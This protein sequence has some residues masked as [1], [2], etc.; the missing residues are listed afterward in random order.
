M[1]FVASFLAFL[2]TVLFMFAL[3]P[4]AKAVGLVDAAKGRKRKGEHDNGPA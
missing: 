3:R 4:I 1:A 2:I